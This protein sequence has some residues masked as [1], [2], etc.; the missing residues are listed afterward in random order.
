MSLGERGKGG[1]REEPKLKLTEHRVEAAEA[2]QGSST[3]VTPICMPT[4]SGE[5]RAAAYLSPLTS[6]LVGIVAE[7]FL[8]KT[9]GLCKARRHLKEQSTLTTTLAIRESNSRRSFLAPPPF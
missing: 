5:P 2:G 8:A 4:D 7:A 1:R 6:F 9:E 3:R